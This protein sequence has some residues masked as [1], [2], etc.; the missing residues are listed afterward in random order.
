MIEKEYVV[1]S[2]R[3]IKSKSDEAEV[4]E[5]VVIDPAALEE[6][7]E[8]FTEAGDVILSVMPRNTVSSKLY[9]FLDESD[10]DKY[11][12]SIILSSNK[13]ETAGRGFNN[14][15]AYESGYNSGSNNVTF[16][17]RKGSDRSSS[18]MNIHNREGISKN[19]ICR[20]VENVGFALSEIHVGRKHKISTG[21]IPGSVT[22]EEAWDAA[23]KVSDAAGV[24]FVGS[25]VGPTNT[26]A[27][28]KAT[29][30][31][32]MHRDEEKNGLTCRGRIDE[33]I[34]LTE[35]PG[36]AFIVHVKLQGGKVMAVC[37]L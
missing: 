21:L 1:I 12:T 11:V 3:K 16:F 24:K 5:V 37:V 13:Y 32:K 7:I 19:N 33:H 26:S 2:S 20:V 30:V 35:S 18:V 9:K 10:K 8:F 36:V 17:H 34:N 4:A 6:E 29:A 23:I 15:G 28:A 27:S 14:Y 22:M 31:T 25:T